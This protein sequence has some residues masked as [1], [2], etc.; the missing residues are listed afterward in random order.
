MR[1]NIFGA[2]GGGIGLVVI[3]H[4]D[5]HNTMSYFQEIP[6]EIM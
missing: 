2:D 3:T 5:I 4:S 6:D 1:R